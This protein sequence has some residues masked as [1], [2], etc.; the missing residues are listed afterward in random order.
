MLRV[1]LPRWSGKIPA[2]IDSPTNRPRRSGEGGRILRPAESATPPMKRLRLFG[3]NP[4]YEGSISAAGA[5]RYR[6]DSRVRPGARLETKRQLLSGFP[7]LCLPDLRIKL[8]CFAALEH[9]VVAD[10]A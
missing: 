4:G 10:D 8:R 2:L 1:S 6:R 3:R 9:A 5:V 7:H